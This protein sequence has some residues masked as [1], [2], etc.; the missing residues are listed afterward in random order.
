MMVPLKRGGDALA[1]VRTVRCGPTPRLRATLG[2]DLAG[3]ALYALAMPRARPS[4][5]SRYTRRNS[6]SSGIDS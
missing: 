4:G 3:F 6:S 5:V 1:A 2:L